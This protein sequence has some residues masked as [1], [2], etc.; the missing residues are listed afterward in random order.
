MSQD[1]IL[2]KFKKAIDHEDNSWRRCDKLSEIEQR[3]NA[4]EMI[5]GI[6]EAGLFVLPEGQ[7]H[8]LVEYVH[9][10]GFNH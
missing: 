10:K 2:D 6:V 4:Q 9:S 3:A 8:E 5:Y 7:Y 1:T